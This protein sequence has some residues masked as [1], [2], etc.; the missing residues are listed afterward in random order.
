M[1]GFLVAAVLTTF[2]PIADKAESAKCVSAG[3]LIQAINE[4]HYKY[5]TIDDLGLIKAL[6]K[7]IKDDAG[8]G[9]ED[10]TTTVV[11]VYGE[12]K[13]LLLEFS[14]AGCRVAFGAMPTKAWHAILDRSQA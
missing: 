1:F 12:E 13:T 4:A 10:A 11:V 8:E 6:S 14:A 2:Q 7:I 3:S 9:F 5:L